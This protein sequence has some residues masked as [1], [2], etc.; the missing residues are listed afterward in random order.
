M[1]RSFVGFVIVTVLSML[2]FDTARPSEP[3]SAAPSL[4]ATVEYV[5]QHVDEQVSLRGTSLYARNKHGENIEVD[6]LKTDFFIAMDSGR[7]VF[8]G[9]HGKFRC[10]TSDDDDS[11][12]R[13]QYRF[14]TASEPEYQNR[15]CNA[16]IHLLNL[17][18]QQHPA[19]SDPF[20]K[21]PK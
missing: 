13:G 11:L 21:G 9:C 3:E 14:V 15:V 17:I 7:V 1:G 18:K 10:A 19:P 8:V 5:N 20:E 2:A 16:L 4:D 6:L 12:V